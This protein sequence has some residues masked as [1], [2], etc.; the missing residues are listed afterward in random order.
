MAT[1]KLNLADLFKSVTST[2]VD[3]KKSLNEADSYNKNHGD[4]MVDIF[5][6]I[7]QAMEEKAGA[8]P[9]DQLAYASQ[10]LRQKSQSGSA[11]MYVKGLTQA[12]ERF[13]GQDITTGN[14]MELIQTLLG[15]GEAQPL[16]SSP[17]GDLLGSLLTG[18]TGG[19]KSQSESEGFDL[20]DLLGA[21]MAFM[22]AKQEGDS[23]VEALVDAVV[24][25]SQMGTSSHR[26]QS[27][28][29]VTNT[30][31]QVIGSMMDK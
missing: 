4:N 27:S 22:Q 7:T 26:A 21:G 15:G 31:L 29:L 14:A 18:L 11:Q 12:A 20:G 30:L 28:T 8:D 5:K 2:L 9:A 19:E 17:T 6:V 25:T 10:L 24:S 16:Q 23:N 1:Q 3:N 13:Q